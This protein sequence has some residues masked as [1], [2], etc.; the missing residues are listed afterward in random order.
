VI[1]RYLNLGIRVN[2]RKPYDA[3]DS[4]TGDLALSR[5]P[6]NAMTYDGLDGEL[7]NAQFMA[8]NVSTTGLAMR[9]PIAHSWLDYMPGGTAY[10]PAPA[11]DTLT[12]WMSGCPLARWT[13]ST[14]QV[15]I[16]HIGTI[17]TNPI[18]N[19][20]VK[21]QFLA[22]MEANT[23]AFNPFAAWP[24]AE[25]AVVQSKFKKSSVNPYIM[26]LIT[27]SGEF[28]AILIFGIMPRSGAMNEWCIGGCK[29]VAPMDSAQL[30][31][32]LS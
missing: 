12:G 13:S 6:P 20:R 29:Q 21:S 30:R 7:V 18:A 16:G 2:W 4:T 25:I 5:N 28:Y 3:P 19:A 8:V 14:G 26:G 23:T 1:E 24:T 31:V 10:M 9:Q 32:L 15:F 17:D 22:T 27:A 11:Q